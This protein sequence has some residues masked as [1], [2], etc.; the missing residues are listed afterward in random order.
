MLDA[1]ARVTGAVEYLI[2]LRLPGMLA[3]AIV[4]STVPHARIVRVDLV[5]AEQVTGAR[6]LLPGAQLAP[7]DP[8]GA[9]A[10]WQGDRLCV[11][12]GTQAPYLLRAALARTFALPEDEVRVI[13][14]PLGGGYGGKGG[15]FLEPL[16]AAV[17]R[18][19]G[20]RPVK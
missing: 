5:K 3:G 4:R 17:A 16:V 19:A 9:V 10:Q 8:H 15:P 2:N 7:L 18:R 20:G 1:T 14:P 11:W 6:A 13:V 12:S